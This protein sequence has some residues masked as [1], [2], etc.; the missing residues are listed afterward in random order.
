MGQTASFCLHEDQKRCTFSST[1]VVPAQT[2]LVMVA[3]FSPAVG[4]SFVH[5]LKLETLANAASGVLVTVP[6]PLLSDSEF[7]RTSESTVGL[8]VIEWHPVS[9]LSPGLAGPGKNSER[10]Q[11]SGAPQ[12]VKG[13]GVRVGC[14]CQCHGR[15][16]QRHRLFCSC[17][18]LRYHHESCQAWSRQLEH[19]AA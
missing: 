14:Q 18:S 13:P 17:M 2:S 4:F 11:F 7:R 10:A 12:V 15:S 6:P 1:V 9:N 16:D 19:A 5:R 8:V 3:K